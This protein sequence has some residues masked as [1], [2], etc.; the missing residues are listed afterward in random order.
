MK[1][2]SAEGAVETKVTA[3]QTSETETKTEE[4]A[5]TQNEVQLNT[6]LVIVGSV[7]GCCVFCALVILLIQCHL[8]HQKLS[9]ALDAKME[10]HRNNHDNADDIVLSSA[11]NVDAY[12][13][14][15]TDPNV[16]T[17]AVAASPSSMDTPGADMQDNDALNTIAMAPRMRTLESDAGSYVQEGVIQSDLDDIHEEEIYATPPGSTADEHAAVLPGNTSTGKG[18]RTKG[19][20]DDVQTEKEKMNEQND[21]EEEDDVES[22]EDEA[23]AQKLYGRGKT[24]KK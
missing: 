16:P 13:G 9:Q 8:K 23:D 1:P 22:D 10:D 6:V 11:P 14:L 5:A 20:Q 3:P 24:S 15:T 18:D 12:Q 19:S 2:T 17:H 7:V 21:E 4:D